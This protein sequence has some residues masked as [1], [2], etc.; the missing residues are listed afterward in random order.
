MLPKRTA[1]CWGHI[2][3]MARAHLLA[4]EKGRPGETYIIAGPPHSLTEAFEIAES[5]TGVPA[6]KRHISPATMR[7]L[8]A[9]AKTF[10]LLAF[11]SDNDL[12]ETLRV[13]AGATYLGSHAKARRELDFRPRA[14]EDGLRETLQ[15]EMQ[16]LGI[17]PTMA[18]SQGA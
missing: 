18:P 11:W 15:H 16:L 17:G 14:L 13:G 2:D 10:G 6:P 5:I 1:Y 12:A 9:V 7:F 8:S 3:D 4:M